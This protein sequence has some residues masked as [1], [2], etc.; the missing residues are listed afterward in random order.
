M[1]CSTTLQEFQAI[2]K[3]YPALVELKFFAAVDEEKPQ[4]AFIAN[5]LFVTIIERDHIVMLNWNDKTIPMLRQADQLDKP[6]LPIFTRKGN[7]GTLPD[8]RMVSAGAAKMFSSQTCRL[9]SSRKLPACKRSNSIDRFYL[10]RVSSAIPE[11]WE[12]W[13]KDR[14]EQERHQSGSSERSGRAHVCIQEFFL[15]AHY[16]SDSSRGET[17]WCYHAV[18]SFPAATTCGSEIYLRSSE[19]R[20]PKAVYMMLFSV[21]CISLKVIRRGALSR[22][23]IARMDHQRREGDDE[24]SGSRDFAD[25]KQ[26][27]DSVQVIPR[28]VEF[29]PEC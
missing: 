14:A 12:A 3:E 18:L 6:A 7:P 29:T 4:S 15:A 28:N 2:T 5:I 26:A 16:G 25:K 17:S 8:L 10:P 11:M 22:F 19:M 23:C 24:S 21:V 9:S 20:M 1:L 27:G 13:E